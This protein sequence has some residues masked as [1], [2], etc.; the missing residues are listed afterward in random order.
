MRVI[1]VTSS[2]TYVPGN[3]RCLLE[4][5]ARPDRLPEG[6]ELVH[7]LFLRVPP[8]YVWR[9]V[10]GLIAIGAPYVGMTLLRN[11]VQSTMNDPRQAFLRR[12]GVPFSRAGNINDEDVLN[13]LRQLAPDL[14][15]NMRTR[16]IYRRAVLGIPT[17][18][19]INIHHG[20]L[21]EKNSTAL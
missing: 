13:R 15:V 7:V 17:M 20:L 10:V 8:W 18:G 9:N 5:V 19:C 11:L 12:H 6:I 4:D 3:Y 21:P 14:M 16:N 1:F 2:V